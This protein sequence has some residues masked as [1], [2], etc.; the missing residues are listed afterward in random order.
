MAL[1]QLGLELPRDQAHIWVADDYL[2]HP[3]LPGGWTEKATQD[4][5]VYY[6]NKRLGI[7]SWFHPLL[8]YYRGLVYMEQ[9]GARII[10]QRQQQSGPPSHQDLEQMARYLSCDLAAEPDIA[11][12]MAQ[13]SNQED[14]DHLPCPY[15][16]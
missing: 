3:G 2:N 6:Q 10:R 8:L 5:R 1:R 13:A 7:T 14:P 4:G 11:P 9:Q 15:A 16:P 12:L